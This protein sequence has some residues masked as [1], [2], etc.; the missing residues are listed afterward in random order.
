M[1]GRLAV[2]FAI[3][4]A[5]LVEG[6]AV[7]VP[8]P[9]AVG[10]FQA[11]TASAA[12]GQRADGF[13][14]V[15]SREDDGGTRI[16]LTVFRGARAGPILAITAGIH[17]S[18]YVPIIALQRLLSILDAKEM[19]GTV[20]LV[21]IANPPS[22]LKRTVYYGP[23][24]WKNLE[25]AFPGKADGTLTE[26]IADRLTSEVIA[27]SDDFV[28]VHCG[29]GNEALR[30]YVSYLADP[31][32]S[33]AERSRQMAV[34]FG[35]DYVLIS[36][37]G[38]VNHGSDVHSSETAVGNGRPSVAVEAGELGRTDEDVIDQVV[39][40][41]VRVMKHLGILRGAA[42]TVRAPTFIERSALIKSPQTGIFYPLVE[43]GQSVPEGARLGIVT[44]FFGGR[45]AEPVAPFAGVVMY[46]VRTPP[47]SEGEPIAM[48]GEISKIPIAKAKP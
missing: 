41:L 48:V 26:R 35:I 21:Q 19:A 6:D 38:P 33:I 15:A 4:V 5:L 32:P 43:A 9:P 18:E 7:A 31:D 25:R 42:S 23:T 8:P 30:P 45:I 27:R 39:R 16:P 47:I 20:V 11:G 34:A 40:G 17:G 36:R 46:V 10:D 13:I 1:T 12:P 37:T 14:D 28:D 22:F 24:D 2:V 29:D 44:N 3:A